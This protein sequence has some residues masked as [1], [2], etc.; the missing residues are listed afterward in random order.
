MK[1]NFY[2]HDSMYTEPQTQSDTIT[3]NAYT[4][5]YVNTAKHSV[6]IHSDIIN[7]GRITVAPHRM[8][9]SHKHIKVKT[10]PNV[11]ETWHYKI[12][13]ACALSTGYVKEVTAH[14]ILISNNRWDDGSRYVTDELE[15]IE[16][17]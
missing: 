6:P 17:L 15:F 1:V 5:E 2:S 10:S 4:P 16:K 8:Y 11:G 12:P 7:T 3:I 14:T 9:D 13:G